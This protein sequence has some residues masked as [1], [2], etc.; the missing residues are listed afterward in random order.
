MTCD[1]RKQCKK[2]YFTI[3]CLELRIVP[4]MHGEFTR[5]RVSLFGHSLCETSH[6]IG[7]LTSQYGV[8]LTSCRFYATIWYVKTDNSEPH[9]KKKDGSSLHLYFHYVCYI[10][11]IIQSVVSGPVVT[12][13]LW[14]P[15]T[16]RGVL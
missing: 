16:L 11:K 10:I 6:C 8:T 9:K 4:V 13:F 5:Y 12:P 2:D 3:Q 14:L 15:T 7:I 1:C